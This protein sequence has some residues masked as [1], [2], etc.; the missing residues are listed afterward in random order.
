MIVSNNTLVPDADI[1]VQGSYYDVLVA[2]RDLVYQGHELL[3][4]PL[5]ASIRMLFSPVRTIILSDSRKQPNAD[6]EYSMSLIG[7]AI[8]KYN[9]L[10]K[11]RTPDFEH[12]A[13][14]ELLDFELFQQ[15]K[16]ELKY[17]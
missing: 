11:N 5:F 4:H 8:I 9:H 12:T 17:C 15:A 2:A 16:R 6:N 10:L 14:Y 1:I 13:D 7:D 3:V